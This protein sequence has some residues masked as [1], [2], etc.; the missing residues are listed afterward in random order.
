ML[1]KRLISQLALS[2]VLLASAAVPTM[3]LAHGDGHREHGSRSY[4]GHHGDH[5]W[6]QERRWDRHDRHDGR[7]YERRH[8]APPVQYAPAP[9]LPRPGNGVTVILRNP[10]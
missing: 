2:A 4:R 7:V 5:H 9:V 6:K 8:I 10:W 3:A 1:T